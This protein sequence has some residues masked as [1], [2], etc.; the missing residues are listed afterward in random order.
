MGLN[1]ADAA[2]S[3][4]EDREMQN[5]VSKKNHKGSL[6]GLF[7]VLAGLIGIWLLSALAGGYL[8]VSDPVGKSSAVVMLSGGGEERLSAA[9][10]LFKQRT[11]TYFIITET[12]EPY[13]GS[14]QDVSSITADKVAQLGIKKDYILI[15]RGQSLSTVEEAKAVLSLAGKRHLTSLIVVTDNFH[16]RRTR[17]VFEDTFKESGITISVS[18]AKTGWYT[19]WTWWMTSE[20]RTAFFQEYVK[21]A[22][23]KLGIRRD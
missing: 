7:T 20:G 14:A 13:S 15:T 18:P 3:R 5:Q 1:R 22:A 2:G 12:G 21:M 9:G 8:I 10:A 17:M 11:A 6:G 4:Q 16:T 23:Y 19:P